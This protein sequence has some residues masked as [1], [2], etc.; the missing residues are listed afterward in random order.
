MAVH[1]RFAPIALREDGILWGGMNFD[2]L[3]GWEAVHVRQGSH[4]APSRVG[5]E[6]VDEVEALAAGHDGEA[7]LV[8]GVGEGEAG[9]GIGEGV[10]AAGTGVAEGG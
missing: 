10:A 5:E 3:L 9:G 2:G 8:H 4:C 6:G 7:H 1:L